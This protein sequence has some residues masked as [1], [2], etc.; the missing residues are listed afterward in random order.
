[1]LIHEQITAAV[2]NVR[3][4]VVGSPSTLDNTIPASTSTKSANTAKKPPAVAKKT[5][6]PS[7]GS[8]AAEYIH[9]CDPAPW[10]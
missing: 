3:R 2:V 1:M 4:V 8:I 10:K 7:K 5:S 9:V 6:M